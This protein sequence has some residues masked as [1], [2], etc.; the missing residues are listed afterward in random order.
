[1]SLMLNWANPN[2]TVLKWTGDGKMAGETGRVI[3]NE[4]CAVIETFCECGYTTVDE[5]LFGKQKPN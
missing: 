3:R 2:L 1:M 4:L 5:L